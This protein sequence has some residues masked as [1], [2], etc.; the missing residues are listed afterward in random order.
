MVILAL[1]RPSEPIYLRSADRVLRPALGLKSRAN[2][3]RPLPE[4]A[5]AVDSSVLAPPSD[6]NVAKPQVHEEFL[7]EVFEGAGG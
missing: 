5:V 2:A 4:V 6:V 7:A 3:D 1:N